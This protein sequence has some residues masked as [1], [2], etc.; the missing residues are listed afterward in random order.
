M[1]LQEIE[2]FIDPNGQVRIEV[3][4]VKGAACLDLT[5]ALEQALGGQ[6]EAR[7]MTPE[8]LEAPQQLPDQQQ[9]QQ[10]AA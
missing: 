10:R 4:G 9:D 5:K 1:E 3:R 7:E 6:V 2:V 8:A